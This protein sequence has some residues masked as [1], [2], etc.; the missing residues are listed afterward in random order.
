VSILHASFPD[1]LFN[2]SR[3]RGFHCDPSEFHAELS[4]FCFGVMEK[5]LHFNICD[6]ETSFVFDS[7]VPDLQHKI[8][9]NISDALFYS[10]KHWGNHLVKG[11]FAEKIHGKLIY[12]LETHLL[13]WM[14]VLNVTRHI[15]TGPKL[16][17]NALNWLKVSLFH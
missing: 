13:F 15:T 4:T 17:L 5:Q 10:C 8:E 12:F 3:S 1:F 9:E 14:E 2:K 6:L 11:T 7:D 16:L